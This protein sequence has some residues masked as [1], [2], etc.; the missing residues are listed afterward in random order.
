[1]PD[2]ARLLTL[3]SRI[4]LVLAVV[5]AVIFVRT[6]AWEHKNDRVARIWGIAGAVYVLFFGGATLLLTHLIT[7]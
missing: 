4:A 3:L 1:M 5:A 7:G 2:L 6:R